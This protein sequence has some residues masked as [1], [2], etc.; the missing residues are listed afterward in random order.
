M[1]R[2]FGFTNWEQKFSAPKK[3]VKEDVVKIP[4]LR[5]KEGNNILRIITMPATYWQIKFLDGKSKF[6][7]RVNCSD[8]VLNKET[9]HECPTV[10][11]GYKPKPRYIVGVLDRSDKENPVKLYDMSVAVYN[12]LHIFNED[13]AYGDPQGY[14]INVK[15]DPDSGS[16][17]TF[18]KVLPRPASPLSE[19]DVE[20]ISAIGVD[21]INENISRLTAPYNVERVAG[22]LKKL[23]WDGT[24]KEPVKAPGA[25]SKPE[26]A[27]TAEEDYSFDKAAQ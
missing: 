17:Q 6:G 9:A 8:K 5:L 26:L 15:F 20:A 19:A 2:E 11:A 21:I 7:T 24:V 12:E 3:E 18:Y 14:D 27:E 25:K 22:L 10:Q 1:A 23:G 16:P 13:S 4:F